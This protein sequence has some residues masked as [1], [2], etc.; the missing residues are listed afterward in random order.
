MKPNNS[1]NLDVLKRSEDDSHEM[2]GSLNFNNEAKQSF[3][4]L[5]GHAAL[6]KASLPLL[7]ES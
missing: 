2:A 7:V 1:R 6:F 3:V 5:S 4:L